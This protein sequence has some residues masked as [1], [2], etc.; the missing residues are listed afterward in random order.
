MCSFCVFQFDNKGRN[1][2]HLAVQKNDMESVLF[3]ISVR[4]NVNSRVQD[5]SQ[6]TPLHLAVQT[7][8]DIMV[9]NLVSPRFLCLYDSTSYENDITTTYYKTVETPMG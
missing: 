4:A 5:A 8:S 9:R 2:L 1:F 3:L 7:G 6:M